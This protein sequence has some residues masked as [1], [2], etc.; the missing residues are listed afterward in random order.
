MIF[1]NLKYSL[2]ITL[3][4]Y[5]NLSNCFIPQILYLQSIKSDISKLRL[6]YLNSTKLDNFNNKLKL[7]ILCT[8]SLILAQSSNAAIPNVNNNIN[9]ASSI[10][11]GV[12]S[13][14][15]PSKVKSTIENV[16]ISNQIEAIEK[17]QSELFKKIAESTCYISTD[18]SSMATQLNLDTEQVPTGVGSG[19]I[20][21]K[22][23]H[24]VTN[25]H[26]INK[27]D[28]AKITLT[29]KNGE[30]KEY[31]AKL[32]GVDPD[33]DLAVL[34][35]DAPEKELINIKIG[36]SDNIEIGQFTYALGNP[37]GQDNSFSSGIISGLNRIIKAPTGRKIQGV[38][39]TDAAI[40][41]GNSGG[42]L[43]NS[44]GELIAINS[45]SMGNGVS[46]GVGL[47]IPINSVKKSIEELIKDGQVHR[48]IMG[49]SYLERNPTLT[50]SNRGGMP[51][52]KNGVIVLDVSKG[53]GAD[54][55][56]LMGIVQPKD[57][58]SKP[59]FGDII[60]GID[61]YVINEPSDM[62]NI[63]EKYKPGDMISLKILRGNEKIC[64]TLSIKLDAFQ[65]KT[66]TKME[67]ERGKEFDNNGIPINIPLKD[68][69]AKRD[70]ELPKV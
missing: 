58:K 66:F 44:K 1:K 29:L 7:G 36:N 53:G 12:S 45:A 38:I 50:E 10:S 67:N 31:I 8:S 63:L 61:D 43:V 52:V 17:K 60:I 65:G 23:G 14:F 5:I 37:F 40:N 21:D 68:M 6:N 3:I 16:P 32:T 56:G 2:F 13:L 69:A 24:I 27:V 20:W 22:L 46:S 48:A 35:I 15:N 51:Y 30:K 25:F 18:Y 62:N 55:G 42:P 39:Q 19:F 54:N 57:K 4:L 59:I 9:Y 33:K 11:G 26:V 34:K 28:D 70:L 47:A 49:I 64:K 41:P